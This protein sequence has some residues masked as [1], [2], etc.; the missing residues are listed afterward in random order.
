MTSTQ[1]MTRDEQA[2][3]VASQLV[4]RAAMLTRLLDYAAAGQRARTAAS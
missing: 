2:M 4:P 3:H 1:S